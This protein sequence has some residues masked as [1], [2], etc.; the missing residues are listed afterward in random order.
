MFCCL[1]RF[2]EIELY[3]T[4]PDLGSI[5]KG[6]TMKF[7]SIVCP[8]ILADRRDS[9]KGMKWVPR[10]KHAEGAGRAGTKEKDNA[11]WPRSSR[12]SSACA[13]SAALLPYTPA[14]KIRRVIGDGHLYICIH[15]TR[16]FIIPDLPSSLN[17]R[18]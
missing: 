12:C 8:V 17:V 15:M 1:R 4:V 7:V 9:L 13:A 6:T 14:H 5:N 16:C 2:L 11:A 10:G 3:T 18:D